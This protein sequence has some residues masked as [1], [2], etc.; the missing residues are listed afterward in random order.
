M[1]ARALLCVAPHYPDI[2]PHGEPITKDALVPN[3]HIAYWTSLLSP[4]LG[5]LHSVLDQRDHLCGVGAVHLHCCEA[6]LAAGVVL[7]ADEGLVQAAARVAHEV[8][9]ADVVEV[10]VV[11]VLVDAA[12][13]AAAPAPAAAAEYL[14]VGD[15]EGLVGEGVPGWRD[16][17]DPA[18][19]AP[20]LDAAVLEQLFLARP[21]YF[22]AQHAHGGAPQPAQLVH[23]RL[24]VAHT[25]DAHFIQVRLREGHQ[26]L[27]QDPVFLK[28]GPQ[29]AQPVL[30]QPGHHLRHA[31]LVQRLLHAAHRHVDHARRIQR[32]SHVRFGRHGARLVPPSRDAPR[33]K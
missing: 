13:G 31:Q 24:L 14:H 2:K 19:G 30:P 11:D 20:R 8:H 26:V 27:A 32:R 3:L 15:F 21:D 10:H 1:D 16:G 7:H 9:V 17:A 6:V 33:G 29:V 23:H 22:V 25:H 18:A 12:A 4:H 5:V 28:A